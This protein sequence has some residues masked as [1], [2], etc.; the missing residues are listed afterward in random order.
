MGETRVM[1]NHC[2]YPGNIL[3]KD[4][5]QQNKFNVV[6]P[7]NTNLST[8]N[9][10]APGHKFECMTDKE[11]WGTKVEDFCAVQGGMPSTSDKRW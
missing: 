5:I 10:W 8:A 2:G 3:V 4:K 9:A 7:V 6:K 1:V 11:Y